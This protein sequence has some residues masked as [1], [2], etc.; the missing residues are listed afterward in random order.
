MKN[1]AVKFDNEYDKPKTFRDRKKHPSKAK[2]REQLEENLN[3]V[4]HKDAVPYHRT[5]KGNMRKRFEEE[6]VNNDWYNVFPGYDKWWFRD[7]SDPGMRD[8]GPF[9]TSD[10]AHEAAFRYAQHRD[11]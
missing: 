9:D 1:K 5:N 2:Q 6:D 10:D 4:T 11:L 8:H 7:L 3:A